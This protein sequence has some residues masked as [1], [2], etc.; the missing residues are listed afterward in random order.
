MNKLSKLEAPRGPGRYFSL[1]AVEA[2]GFAIIMLNGMPIYHEM[3]RD[4][5]GHK[6]QPGVL[7]WAWAG[8]ILTLSAYIIRVWLRPTMPRSGH[9]IAGHILSFVGRLSFVAATSTFSLVFINHVGELN[10]PPYRM[11][12]ILVLLFAMFCW[13]LELERLAK[14]LIG[15]AGEPRKPDR[16]QA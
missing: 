7:W 2:V 13:N 9:A 6:P 15:T 4:V 11:A 1:L 16:A 10:L 14:A 5:S 3:M 12:V 8:V